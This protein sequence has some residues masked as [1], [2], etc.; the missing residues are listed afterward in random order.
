MPK[1]TTAKQGFDLLDL[2]LEN[3][4]P[5]KELSDEELDDPH[6]VNMAYKKLFRELIPG[7]KDNHVQFVLAEV[8][9]IDR[10]ESVSR[11]LVY[12][13][14]DED[15]RTHLISEYKTLLQSLN[16]ESLISES[17]AFYLTSK[18]WCAET[19]GA[20]HDGVDERTREWGFPST[21]KITKTGVGLNRNCDL[22]SE[23]LKIKGTFE[24]YVD[25]LYHFHLK[26][27]P[28]GYV[29]LVPICL[30]SIFDREESLKKLGAV[31]LHFTT[32]K[33]LE[34]INLQRIYGRTVLFWHYYFTSEAVDRRQA[35]A[36]VYEKI[37]PWLDEIQK[38]FRNVRQPLRRLE[39]E[40]NPI[41][42]L[43]DSED[44]REFFANQGTV[45]LGGGLPEISPRHAWQ[46]GNIDPYK[47]IVA[48]VLIRVLSLENR[49]EESD[50]LWESVATVLHSSREVHHKRLLDVF[51][52]FK[53][54]APNPQQ[55]E[56]AFNLVKSWF[57]DSFKQVNSPGI[58]L[59]LLAYVMNDWTTLQIGNE[60]EMSHFWVAS[61][62]PVET[63]KALEILNRSYDIKEA[64]LKLDKV[65]DIVSKPP[66]STAQLT[67]SFS[68][69]ENKA[70]SLK[71]LK[72]SVSEALRTG[73]KPHGNMT[74]FLWH[75]VGASKLKL[76]GSR[77][78]G[79]SQDGELSIDFKDSDKAS[80][81]LVINWRGRM[82]L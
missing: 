80:N 64:S 21:E 76:L 46:P 50:D 82:Y 10:R 79:K 44:A 36:D 6:K 56:E 59:S 26:K 61:R 37:K 18:I 49:I 4:F 75:M 27:Y 78:V 53:N 55:V 67:L 7:F 13:D 33:R 54:G 12:S 77:F 14:L 43:F 15:A 47:Q 2:S 38:G 60:K 81:E 51:P 52:G 69:R 8:L 70:V 74:E 29:L 25:L 45:K 65:R 32:S 17:D 35:R 62:T 73:E 41:R 42:G 19:F 20:R 40:L 58:P 3:I 11:L 48:G 22:N 16:T 24:Q 68:F 1:P 71:R 28:F 39:A 34:K 57:S 72:H 9:E 63:I 31:F 23:E 30:N 66:L 5:L